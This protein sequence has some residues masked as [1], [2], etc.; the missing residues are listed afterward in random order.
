MRK[1]SIMV[2]TFIMLLGL[3]S[4]DANAG[5]MHRPD[6][7]GIAK[8][9]KYSYIFNY[10]YN[11]SYSYSYSYFFSWMRDDDGD[12]IPNGLDPDYEKPE[13]G[14]GYGKLKGN[15]TCDNDCDGTP[16]RTRDRLQ[17][18]LKLKDCDRTRIL[19]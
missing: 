4:T 5:A 3:V 17:L 18:H 16:D 7:A 10:S 6:F 14:T 8:M 13:D 19:R 11:Y 2:V 1:I 15:G 9:Y 12:G